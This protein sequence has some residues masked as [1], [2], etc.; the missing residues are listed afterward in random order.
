M[1]FPLLC[2]IVAMATF[3]S[4]SA[5]TADDIAPAALLGKTFTFTITGG[6]GTVLRTGVWKGTFG[7][8][9]SKSFSIANVSGNTPGFVTTYTTTAVTQPIPGGPAFLSIYLPEVFIDSGNASLILTVAETSNQFTLTSANTSTFPAKTSTQRGTFT[10]DGISPVPE[11][12]VN[13]AA[14]PLI[15][16][17]ASKISLGSVKAGKSSAAKSFTITNTGTADLTGIAITKSGTNKADFVVVA[18]TKKTLGAGKSTNFKVTFKPG[19][20][21]TKNAAIH[22]ASNDADE[23]PFDIKLTGKATK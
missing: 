4:A 3:S 22:I 21:G 5:L 11:I 14:V 15:D 9:P 7:E 13:L 16:G 8:A 19:S 2:G 17:S 6:S 10:I 12:A 20:V 1:K 23:N 18:P